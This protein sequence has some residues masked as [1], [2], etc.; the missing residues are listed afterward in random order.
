LI[1]GG[2]TF[3]QSRP[4]MRTRLSRRSGERPRNLGIKAKRGESSL[5]TTEES[6][7]GESP[8]MRRSRGRRRSGRVH[9]GGLAGTAGEAGRAAGKGALS[10]FPH[11]RVAAAAEPAPVRTPRRGRRDSAHGDIQARCSSLFRRARQDD[12]LSFRRQS[13]PDRQTR[14]SGE[15]GGFRQAAAQRCRRGSAS[16]TS[17]S[18]QVP[19]PK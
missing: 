19:A 8:G 5:R 17:R 13:E 4:N 7:R 6:G 11:R 14:L 9:G 16:P 3:R 10:T 18:C 1:A 12:D 15:A 2:P